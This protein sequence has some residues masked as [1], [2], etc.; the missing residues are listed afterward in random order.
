MMFAILMDRVFY[1]IYICVAVSYICKLHS[2]LACPSNIPILKISYCLSSIAHQITHLL[3]WPVRKNSF[4]SF[5][6]TLYERAKRAKRVK[7]AKR[8]TFNNKYKH[9]VGAP[10]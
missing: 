10:A 2:M 1:Y 5:C 9:V 6:N 8:L 3:D 4:E 7:R